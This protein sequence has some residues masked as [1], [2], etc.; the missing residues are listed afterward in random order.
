LVTSAVLAQDPVPVPPSQT[1][2]KVQSVNGKL[3]SVDSDAKK[4]TITSAAGDDME[5]TYNDQTM[6]VGAEST[7][8]GLAG[9]SGADVTVS[10]NED[11]GVKTA[12]RIDVKPTT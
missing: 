9:K 11:Q 2:E 5:F 10:F 1:E 7:V 12:T 4:L 8:E 6:I 3:K